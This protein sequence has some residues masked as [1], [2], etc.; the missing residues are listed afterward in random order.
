MAAKA[1]R[2]G[3]FGFGKR[4]EPANA[5]PVP[6]SIAAT[7]IGVL[8]AD[9]AAKAVIDKYFPGVSGDSRIGMAKGMTLRAVQAFAPDMF[10]QD[11][12]D[13]ADRDLSQLPGR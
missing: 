9:P 5:S 12:L 6:Y 4:Q 10:K 8:L 13:A 2:K 1:P 3:F 11:L 7:K